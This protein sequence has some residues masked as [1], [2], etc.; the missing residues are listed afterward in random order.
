MAGILQAENISKSYGTKILF[1]NLGI[2]INEGDKIALIAPNGSGKSSLLKILA[3]KD[4]SDS[5]GVVRLMNGI[6]VVYLEQDPGFDEQ[7]GVFEEVFAASD[8][9][10][11]AVAEYESA[12][13]SEEHKRLEKAI[14]Q[15]DVID[16]WQYEQKVKRILSR[17]NI[18]NLGQKMGE[19]SGGQ[20]KRVALAGMMINEANLIIMD[21]PTN[22]LDLEV[23]EYLEEYLKRSQATIL[24]V[25]HDRYFL[26]R[27]CNQ[28]LELENGKLYTYRGNYSYFLEK[29]QERVD[30]LNTETERVR[31]I[32]RGEL[33]WMR[34]M[35]QARATKAKY[36]INA[37]YDLKKRAEQQYHEK[38]IKIDVKSSRLGRKII[39]CKDVT[40]HYDS[41][42]TIDG[43]T[44]NFARGEK[45]G[46]VGPNG[47]GKSTFLNVITGAIPPDSGEI[48]WGETVVFG[49]Y[50]QNGLE[51]N[52]EDTVIDVVR[53]IAEVATLSDGSA[54]NVTQFL[55][56]FLFPPSTQNTK[57][58][59]LSGGERRRLYLVTVLMK[60]PNFL[61]L[62][63]PTNDLD[64]MSLNVLEE[65]LSNF[66]G[67]LLIVSHDRYFL[68]KLA[69]HLFIFEGEG[70]VKDFVGKYTD[71]REVIKE[72]EREVELAAK[73]VRQQQR[74]EEKEVP[75]HIK[76]KLSFKEQKELEYLESA[77]AELEKEKSS[78]EA[79]LSSGTL[80]PEKLLFSSNRIMEVMS[81]IDCK[82]ERWIELS[83]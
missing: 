65:Y 80:S 78:L 28:I 18:D 57:V 72:K 48:E 20:K 53:Q 33:D 30:I 49:Y 50:R 63:E 15:M 64:I 42:C 2:N 71:Y 11:S 12:L 56:R 3:G 55:T 13:R 22:H 17:L 77:I 68:D 83:E 39:N 19:L 61:I 74:E 35:P 47:V 54:I 58:E 43:F 4:S 40:H 21:E 62:D 36:R 9:L 46:M 41:F 69:D 26:D 27:V 37:F 25:T 38:S 79:A 67:C 73:A 82:S 24:M 5:T 81:L 45:I 16:G 60:N 52:P 6:K 1:E 44:Y 70:V 76:R 75:K 10:S 31:N 66:P 14:H 7:R 32:L 34:R 8:Q 29:R 23:I 51:F 59:K